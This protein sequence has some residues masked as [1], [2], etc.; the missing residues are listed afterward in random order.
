[1]SIEAQCVGA[2]RWRS[3]VALLALVVAGPVLA[4][5]PDLTPEERQWIAEHPVVYYAGAPNISP[6]EDIVDGRYRGLIAAYLDTVSKRTGLRFELVPT[7]TWEASQEAFLAG[8]VDLFPNASITTVRQDVNAQLR[9]TQAYFASPLIF[10]TRGDT[11]STFGASSLDGK[12]VAIRGGVDVQKTLTAVRPG[13]IPVEVGSPDESLRAVIEGRAEAS[14]GTEAT[15][16]PLLQRK[17]ADRLGVASMVNMPPYRAQMGVR[18]SEPLLHSI[19]SKGLDSITA[20]E[21]DGLYER[22]LSQAD[23]GAPSIGSILHYR[24]FEIALATLGMVLMAIFAWQ[25]RM[26]RRR[27]I[28]SEQTKARFLATM[29]H[30]IRTPI[31][32]MVG[33][34]EM[35]ERT[36]LDAR[37]QA[38]VGA[39]ADAADA[40]VDLLD[41]VLDLSKLDAG[42]LTLERLPTDIA[43]VLQRA[44]DLVRPA[45]EEKGLVLHLDVDAPR[46]GR[47]RVDP[48]RLRQVLA[49]LLGNAVKFT[50]RGCVYVDATV[51]AAAGRDGTL[52]VRI[53]D[54]GVG[55]APE[56]LSR[57]FNAY[58]QADESTTREFGGTGL[59]LTI[60]RELVEL[61]GGQIN[62]DSIQGAGTVVSF[63]IP[64][65][66]TENA[67]VSAV[68]PAASPVD[69][70]AGAAAGTTGVPREAVGRVLV[71]EDHPGNRA[72][73]REQLLE[74]GVQPTLVESGAD[75]I[76]AVNAETF[77]LVLMDCHM[78][79]MNG[80]E[81]T[82]RIRALP[83]GPHHLPIVAI[84]AATGAE[85]LAQCLDSGM[86]G[87]LRKPLRLEELRGTLEVWGVELQPD[88]L[89]RDT[90]AAATRIDHGALLR[91]DLAGLAQA[92]AS[93]DGEAWR[94]H[95]HRLAGAASM[96]DLQ[97]LS[98]QARAL[99]TR[100]DAD[101]AVLQSGLEALEAELAARPPGAS[102]TV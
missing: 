13:V 74:L 5:M 70:A 99:E 21:S 102:N 10:V 60:C 54:T 88:P 62:L 73:I 3:A 8:K 68:T 72:L 46:D 64:V 9:Y 28:R 22:Y 6:L 67:R 98:E 56:Q 36:R 87:V 49:N 17:Y 44:V 61:M 19:M 26:Q 43:G 95:A 14:V 34:I 52:Q 82:Q 29:S 71:V 31:N 25:A 75:A 80:Y 40:L 47:W 100:W 84:S 15:L 66:W 37:Q 79:G 24:R 1:M 97:G 90:D 50:R 89:P 39:A 11:N 69:E 92:L 96:L 38:F 55:I 83:A 77:D 33:S 53:R 20:H 63:S 4:R 51:V 86:D 57:L 7:S 41:N 23:Y 93:G 32:A 27:A 2:S 16:V 18:A 78:P 91:E 45:A 42:K 58:S 101:R 35:L 12:R 94:H 85:H 30:E 65:E 76:A 59:G 81:A 48:T